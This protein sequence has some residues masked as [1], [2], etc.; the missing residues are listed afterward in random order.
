[1]SNRQSSIDLVI[2]KRGKPI[3]AVESRNVESPSAEWAAV[4]ESL[5]SRWTYLRGA[6]SRRLPPLLRRT[7]PVDVF[8]QDS[9]HT[10]STVVFE[11]REAW[12][13]LRPGGV[14]IVDDADFGSGFARFAAQARP[15][16]VVV[17]RQE[18]KGG[19]FAVAGK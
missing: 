13:A 10:P 12:N 11:C 7:G 2:E 19:A 3:V 16:W 4:P 14:L 1:M 17:G 6:S 18:G 8:I 15:A 5:R 9:L